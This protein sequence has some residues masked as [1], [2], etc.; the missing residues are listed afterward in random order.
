[1]KA[2]LL[3]A[4][5]FYRRHISPRKGFSC[6][7]RVHRGGPSCSTYGY[8]AVQRHGALI[9]LA[10]IRRRLTRCGDVYREHLPPAAGAGNRHFAPRHQAGFCDAGC[11]VPAG[12]CNGCDIPAAECGNCHLPAGDCAPP[13]EACDCS[14]F[15]AQQCGPSACDGA[16]TSCNGPGDCGIF[17]GRHTR[18]AKKNAHDDDE[19]E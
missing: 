11:D 9:G 6:A 15:T 2:I 14:S 19:A 1:M 13:A 16:I 3:A 17:G 10:L 18:R 7:H 4:I 5:R 12:D 8:R